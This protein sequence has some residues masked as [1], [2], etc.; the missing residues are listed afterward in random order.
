MSDVRRISRRSLAALAAM[1]VLAA[2]VGAA[3]TFAG[4]H[5]GAAELQARAPGCAACV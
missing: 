5:G 1:L 2:G 3:S 4:Y